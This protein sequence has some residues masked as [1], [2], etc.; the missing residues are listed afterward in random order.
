MVVPD[1]HEQFVQSKFI[2]LPS[3]NVN[4]RLPMSHLLES[5]SLHHFQ[6]LLVP[7]REINNPK[8]M[9]VNQTLYLSLPCLVHSSVF[10]LNT[11][12]PTRNAHGRRTATLTVVCLGDTS[13]TDTRIASDWTERS[14]VLKEASV[15]L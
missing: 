7:L 2:I 10:I 6:L 13:S 1:S 5:R 4:P 12:K 14:D 9:L 11:S 15:R 3:G 8:E